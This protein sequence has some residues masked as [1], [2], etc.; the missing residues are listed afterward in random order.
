[1]VFRIEGFDHS[2]IG[3]YLFNTHR[4]ISTPIKYANIDGIRITPNIYISDSEIDYFAEVL[5]SI[6]RGEVKGLQG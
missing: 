2:K 5:L 6:L 3:E 1:M 4:I